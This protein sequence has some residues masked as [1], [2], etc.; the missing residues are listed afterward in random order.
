MPVAAPTGTSL[1]AFTE[2]TT[3]VTRRIEILNSDGTFWKTDAG[4]V[5]GSVSISNARKERR[6]FSIT[7][8]NADRSVDNYP[9]G[10]WYD[11]IIKLYRGVT[12]TNF[13]YEVQLGEFMIDNI[14]QPHF[15]FQIEVAG[16]DRTKQLQLAKFGNSTTFTS[17][18][19][20]ETLIRNIALNGGIT[21]FN[22]PGSTGK[23]VS[24]DLTYER[25]VERWEAVQQIADSFGYDLYFD[26]QGYLTMTPYVDPTTTQLV[27]TFLTG[28]DS[29]NLVAFKKDS[30]DSQIYNTVVVSGAASDVVVPV[31]YTATN[32]TPTS[33][34]RIAA[35]GPRVYT[36]TSPLITTVGDATAL[37]N[38]FLKIHALEQFELNFESIVYPW[39]D[40]N[41]IVQFVD[42]LPIAGQP[43]RFLLTDLTIPLGLSS[44]SG[45]GKRVTIVG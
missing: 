21:K 45:V 16:R 15:P 12:G 7:L 27:W 10:F 13:S 6:S 36:F 14:S 30:A 25:G 42:P 17:G 34:T 22:L 20:P 26:A 18:Q 1:S 31:T 41:S 37:A 23:L 40:V 4:L 3:Q 24:K 39:L 44:M 29:G 28:P 33:P 43:D 38:S 11:K 2:S 19:A 8:D 35:L 5:G 9:G 32:T